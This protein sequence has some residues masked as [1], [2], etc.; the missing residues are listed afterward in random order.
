M[1]R[2][3][4]VLAVVAAG[5]VLIWTPCGWAQPPAPKVIKGTSQSPAKPG[6]VEAA[7]QQGLKALQAGKYRKAIEALEQ[8]VKLKPDLAEAHYQLGLAY[9]GQ[10]DQDQAVKKFQEAL[11]LK[12]V[13]SPARVGLGAIYGQQGLNLLRQG[14]P[15]AAEGQLKAAVRQNPKDDKA[16][17]NLG[18]A[19]GQ[20]NRWR[21]AQAAF[22]KAVALNPR[23]SQAQ[24]NLGI[25]Y[26][27]QG[28]KDGT[29]Q[30]YAAL[31][32][33]DPAA[34]GIFFSLIQNTTTIATPFRF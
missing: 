12:P 9:A 13:F 32:A 27:V 28:N 18:V 30:Q 1:R 6:N 31:T 14:D 8:A 5:S 23:N 24:F 22:Q 4:L 16:F 10:G 29:T 26:Y 2:A 20:Q 17:S 11:R 34:A 25:V 19:L 3:F 33:L 15:A 7:Y 21:E